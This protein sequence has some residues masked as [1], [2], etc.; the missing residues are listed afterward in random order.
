[1]KPRQRFTTWGPVRGLA[2]QGGYSDRDVYAVGTDG[3]LYRD[4]RDPHSWI[5]AIAAARD[6]QAAGLAPSRR[7]HERGWE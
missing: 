1:M 5:A 2:G 6:A 7:N 4:L 3:Y